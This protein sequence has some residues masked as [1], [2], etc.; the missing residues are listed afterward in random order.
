MEMMD[1]DDRIEREKKKEWTDNNI[2]AEGTR[3]IGESLK[4]NTTLVKL[5][6]SCQDN[7][8]NDILIDGK[9]GCKQTTILEQ[10]EQEW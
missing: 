6:L 1:G 9:R 2:R 3:M 7:E 8:I 4:T 5:N 10:K